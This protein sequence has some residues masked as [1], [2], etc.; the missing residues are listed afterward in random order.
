VKNAPQYIRA[1]TLVEIMVVVGIIGILAAVVIP[2]YVKPRATSQANACINNMT[3]IEDAVS[4]FALEHGKKTGD[5]VNY[6]DDLT[7]YLKLTSSGQI[8][9][10]PA[11]GTYSVDTS[12]PR[13][14]VTCSL[15]TTVTPPHLL[16]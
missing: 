12:G 5:P 16:P 3:K 6:P 11:R 14:V 4:Q 9:A 10:C 13:I 15:G 8:P 2:Y 1:F 7:P